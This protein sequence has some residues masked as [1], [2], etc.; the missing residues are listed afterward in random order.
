MEL[1]HRKVHKT[2]AS[3]SQSLVCESNRNYGNFCDAAKPMRTKAS[4]FLRFL[5]YT[6]RRTTVGRTRNQLVAETST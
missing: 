3:S 5:D 6:Q 4:S 2:K 1:F